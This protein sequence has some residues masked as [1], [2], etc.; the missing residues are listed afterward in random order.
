MRYRWLAAAV[1]LSAAVLSAPRSI[2]AAPAAPAAW[3]VFVEYDSYGG[4]YPDLPV[5]YVNSTRMLT[6]LVRRGW[7]VDHLRLIRDARDRAGLRRGLDW[8]AGHARAEDIALLYVAGEYQFFDRDLAWGTTVPAL[9][10]RI[11][12]AHRVLIVETC[13]AE[14][15]TAA[16]ADMSGVA[17]PA[18]GRDELDWWG[19]HSTDRLIQG[20]SFTDYL[21]HALEAQPA[22][23]MPDF[24]AAFD[25]AV[26][27]ARAYFHDVIAA[28]PAALAS[29]H[30]R[31][32][33]P[34]RQ[35]MFPN[36]HLTEK[37]AEDVSK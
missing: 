14:R 33:Y 16:V 8:L 25:V 20:A 31:G 27:R 18:V 22:G 23:G 13:F 21:A 15:L 1:L 19:L 9:W 30:A 35:Q 36:P 32:S 7:P 34:E 24:S 5:G 6:A 11:P 28:T 29:F 10:N 37:K 3:A 26:A 4:R 12:T 17:L 2:T